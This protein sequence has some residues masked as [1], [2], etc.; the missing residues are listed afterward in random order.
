MESL[1]F[2][3]KEYEGCF[4]GDRFV[5]VDRMTRSGR[6]GLA[7]GIVFEFEP[8]PQRSESDAISD[9][10]YTRPMRRSAVRLI[11]Q[12]T[13]ETEYG[14]HDEILFRFASTIETAARAGGR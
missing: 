6:V 1:T 9:E 5:C 12:R 11:N 7:N 4:E 10:G 3:G 8:L 13:G 14:Y 2:R